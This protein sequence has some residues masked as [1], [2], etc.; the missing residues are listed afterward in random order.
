MVIKLFGCYR[1]S[2][3]W[4]MV[5]DRSGNSINFRGST[6]QGWTLWTGMVSEGVEPCDSGEIPAEVKLAMDAVKLVMDPEYL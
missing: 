5:Y 4:G 2:S 1:R 3:E 6:K